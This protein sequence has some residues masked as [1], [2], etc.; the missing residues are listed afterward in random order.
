MS[1]LEALAHLRPQLRSLPSSSSAS[2]DDFDIS[3]FPSYSDLSAFHRDHHGSTGL[4]VEK[5][6]VA[7]ETIVRG[8]RSSNLLEFPHPPL[9]TGLGPIPPSTRKPRS[10]EGSIIES[11]TTTSSVSYTD[12]EQIGDIDEGDFTR[13]EARVFDEL[14]R[15]GGGSI[16]EYSSGSKGA[17][18][19]G[20]GLHD[21]RTTPYLLR[22]PSR[23][24]ASPSAH[25]GGEYDVS[26]N[27]STLDLSRSS[28]ELD[29]SASYSLS[30]HEAESS[31]TTT[32][33]QLSSADTSFV[34]SSL[35]ENDTEA[36]TL[37]EAASLPQRS[38]SLPMPT[39]TPRPAPAKAT[40]QNLPEILRT[41]SSPPNTVATQ[42]MSPMEQAQ[43]SIERASPKL[44]VD[45]IKAQAP[46]CATFFTESLPSPT[47]SA[48]TSVN[49][50]IM[51]SKSS[52]D[53]TSPAMALP[54]KSIGS[55]LDSPPV[56]TNR[57]SIVKRL[58]MGILKKRKSEAALAT[59]A[60]QSSLP[61]APLTKPATLGKRSIST[62]RLSSAYKGS[63]MSPP[64]PTASTTPRTTSS[65]YNIVDVA[66]KAN[67]TKQ[68][69]KQKRLSLL[70]LKSIAT[71][72]SPITDAYPL[73][74]P[75]T[76]TT[77]G[78]GSDM[79]FQRRPS[80]ETDTYDH[81]GGEVL[82]T[83]LRTNGAS[84]TRG[85]GFFDYTATSGLASPVALSFSSPYQKQ[86]ASFGS[87]ALDSSILRFET[88]ENETLAITSAVLVS[89]KASSISSSVVSTPILDGS[90]RFLGDDEAGYSLVKGSGD[91]SPSESLTLAGFMRSTRP[92]LAVKVSPVTNDRPS[93]QSDRHED[94]VQ[95]PARSSSFFG[96]S[97][98]PIFPQTT[99]PAKTS[100]RSP[101]PRSPFSD[102]SNRPFGDR[103]DQEPPSPVW[104]NVSPMVSAASYFAVPDIVAF[105]M[106][107]APIPGGG[108]GLLPP[109]AGLGL[110]LGIGIGQPGA[111]EM[112]DEAD[113]PMTNATRSAEVGDE[114][115]ELRADSEA[116]IQQGRDAQEDESAIYGASEGERDSDDGDEDEDE[117]DEDD[118]PLGAIPGALSAQ[119][120][121][122]QES[123]RA[124]KTQQSERKAKEESSGQA[125]GRRRDPFEFDPAG[126]SA[127]I[128]HSLLPQTD[129]AVRRRSE[130]VP[131]SPSMPLDPVVAESTLTMDSPE[132]QRRM[133]QPFPPPPQVLRAVTM[134]LPPS[135]SSSRENV[136][137]R[138]SLGI[139]VAASR[140]VSGGSLSP[141]GDQQSPR[142]PG[143]LPSPRVSSRQSSNAVTGTD[144]LSPSS[145]SPSSRPSLPASSAPPSRR[146][147]QIRGESAS[148]A[149]SM[150]RHWSDSGGP[151][152]GPSARSRSNTLAS[153]SSGQQH[154]LTP[155][156][157]LAAAVQQ[158]SSSGNS[159]GNGTHALSN[160]TSRSS[161]RSLPAGS[162]PKVPPPP[163]PTTETRIF[164]EDH[165]KRIK[166]PVSAITTC[167]E[168]V[169]LAKKAGVL[170]FGTDAEG[171]FA[172][173]E[174]CRVIGVGER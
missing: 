153:S 155:A 119:K 49:G 108:P 143:G 145:A 38:V 105:P 3:E 160:K 24:T 147:S 84:T 8:D 61:G 18:A 55:S 31:T 114:V 88:R 72:H 165:T 56:T 69:K 75:P 133:P 11:R 80:A 167:A 17:E 10:P 28:E 63:P 102:A 152:A 150:Q 36:A 42:A 109:G 23:D 93:A 79:N 58:S 115:E 100:K 168:V 174:C 136:P 19:L 83:D 25:D 130:S 135:A 13:E 166:V 89:G 85:L 104:S 37:S 54:T 50:R 20:L 107:T 103:H 73:S 140:L 148:S 48:M 52:E 53:T 9:S 154:Q 112:E 60:S 163:I 137:R 68:G 127:A 39:A 95:R 78:L 158:R 2:S 32:R 124:R 164:I 157:A 91:G 131:R 29:S 106:S 141:H 123:R 122:R 14:A 22:A 134:P 113:E 66:G 81:D 149:A 129:D 7:H 138:P 121:I 26:P 41:R 172:L 82:G 40:L 16:G 27:A 46:M 132:M 142:S 170:A 97:S 62:P 99:R 171:G 98:S 110:G 96:P 173:W 161:L 33:G 117:D 43:P 71:S 116:G 101:S 45:V 6:D 35:K 12:D 34:A 5:G 128:G 44:A 118:K 51:S 65:E 21:A 139:N 159:N 74:A 156:A 64:L 151:V 120:S 94:L 144:T 59:L 57:P 90:R 111:L 70:L 146:P 86:T 92:P 76:T 125:R 169:A 1:N 30:T 87:P 77:F 67:G 4:L 126:S 15:L 47:C 162:S